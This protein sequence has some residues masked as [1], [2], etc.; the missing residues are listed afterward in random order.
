[1]LNI[2][3]L[4]GDSVERRVQA[5]YVPGFYPEI[6]GETGIPID[7]R[8]R[9]R[10]GAGCILGLQRYLTEQVRLWTQ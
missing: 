6:D 1:M 3:K 9:A 7:R 4:L 2:R 8:V 5:P 10:A